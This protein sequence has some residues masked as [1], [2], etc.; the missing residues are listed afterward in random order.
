MFPQTLFIL[1][2]CRNPPFSPRH[3][4]TVN[5]V[6]L[7][8]AGDVYLCDLWCL[9]SKQALA[10]ALIPGAVPCFCSGP[11]PYSHYH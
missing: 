5:V 1:S 8:A 4:L 11:S 6:L 10:Q 2:L 3:P 7:G 9:A